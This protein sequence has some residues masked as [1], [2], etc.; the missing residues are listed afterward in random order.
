MSIGILCAWQFIAI[1]SI[2]NTL[3]II[4]SPLYACHSLYIHLAAIPSPLFSIFTGHSSSL[5]LTSTTSV[6][7]RIELKINR[8]SFLFAVLIRKP[9]VKCFIIIIEKFFFVNK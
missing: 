5:R 3:Y 4:A 9:L 8:L 6:I 2:N 7:T 1:P